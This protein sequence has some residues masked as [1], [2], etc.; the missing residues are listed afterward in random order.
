MGF[1][2]QG[3]KGQKEQKEQ[4]GQKGQKGQKRDSCNN[5]Y[6]GNFI[7]CSKFTTYNHKPHYASVAYY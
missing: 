4:K 6:D 3:Q 1:E 7:S 2:T 5:N